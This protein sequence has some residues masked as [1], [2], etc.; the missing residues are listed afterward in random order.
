[1]VAE[2]NYGGRVTD[3]NDRTLISV[4]L[5]DFYCPQMLKKKHQ[6]TECPKY[7]CPL[8][9]DRDSYINYIEEE[10]PINDITQVFGLHDNADITSMIGIT[11]EML[12]IA[13]SLQGSGGGGGAA[14]ESEEQMVNRICDGITG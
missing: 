12:A 7:L 10:L 2:A 3:I 1:M 11:N 9:G 8:E 13:L 5:E 4:I 6:M 14:G